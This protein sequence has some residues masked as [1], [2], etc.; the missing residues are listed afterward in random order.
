MTDE[1]DF[2]DGLVHGHSWATEPAIPPAQHGRKAPP[3]TA[4]IPT[5]STAF[6]DDRMQG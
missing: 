4:A 2:D 1:R 5:P 3:D 6:H